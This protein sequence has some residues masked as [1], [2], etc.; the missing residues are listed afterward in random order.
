ML[1]LH[2]CLG[3][4]LAVMSRGYSLVVVHGLFI[5]V[6]SLVERSLW[7]RGS[8]CTGASAVAAPG[9]QSTGSG[10]VSSLAVPRYVGS[11]WTRDRTHI[12]CIGRWIL[13][14]WTT[15]EAPRYTIIHFIWRCLD[16]A[17]V[18]FSTITYKTSGPF[19]S[20]YKCI[21]NDL[22]C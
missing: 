16:S 10:V 6:A 7:S 9:L 21:S 4:S 19:E 13:Y 2:Y 14:H 8:R 18:V 22:F 20:G 3:F 5:A 15:K 17:W 11:S 1:G 12:S